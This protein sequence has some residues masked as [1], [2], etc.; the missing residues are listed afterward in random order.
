MQKQ[1]EPSGEIL[2]KKKQTI[3]SLL[4]VAG[5]ILTVILMMAAM[6]P[7]LNYILKVEVAVP[8]N[9]ENVPV[10]TPVPAEEL[11]V[12]AFYVQEEDSKDISFIRVETFRPGTDTVYCIDVPTDTKVTL[13]N[14]L[15]KSLQTY[16]PELPQYFK[17]EKMAEGFSKE[18]SYTGCN[19]ILSEVLGISVTHY[20]CGE[21]ETMDDWELMCTGEKV[22]GAFFEKYRDFLAATVSD[23][24]EEERW[25]YFESYQKVTSYIIENAAEGI[26]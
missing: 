25:I 1:E 2:M 21:K 17:L 9:P 12:T 5:G 10:P 22:P 14:E 24:P 4:L 3:R 23:M 11:L 20:I 19:R 13:S 26:E 18:Y 16:C 15:Y 6:I 7:L 8:G